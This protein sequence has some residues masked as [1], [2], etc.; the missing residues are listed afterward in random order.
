M[1][2][3]FL[4]AYSTTLP[5]GLVQFPIMAHL[6]PCKG[7]WALAQGHGEGQLGGEK[8]FTRFLL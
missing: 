2:D 3:G 6:R 4:L 1:L 8:K 5:G 7:S